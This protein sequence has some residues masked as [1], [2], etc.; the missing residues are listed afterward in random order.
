MNMHKIKRSFLEPTFFKQLQ[1]FML[2]PTMP[3]YWED[4]QYGPNDSGFFRHTFY[5]H[6]EPRS[7]DYH[8]YMIPIVKA[9]KC[10]M[11]SNIRAN[12]LMKTDKPVMSD[13]HHDRSFDCKTAILYINTN[14]GYTL[15]GKKEKIKIDSEANKLVIFDSKTLHCAVSQTDCERRIVINFNYV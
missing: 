5:Y 11:L 9:L 1:S 14:N 10:E 4:H 8:Q 2:S 7:Q 6:L 12:C 3:W 13:F 15:L